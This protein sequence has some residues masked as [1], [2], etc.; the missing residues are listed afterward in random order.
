MAR[1]SPAGEP[2]ACRGRFVSTACC[3]G[4]R[5]PLMV[6]RSHAGRV[7]LGLLLLILLALAAAGCGEDD[8]PNTISKDFG[9]DGERLAKEVAEGAEKE[10]GDEVEVRCP[11]RVRLSDG[12]HVDCTAKVGGKERKIRVTRRGNVHEWRLYDFLDPQRV[13]R[14]IEAAFRERGTTV[15]AHCERVPIEEGRVSSCTASTAQREYRITVRQID[16]LGTI[17]WDVQQ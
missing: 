5:V 17:R 7:A 9:R 4:S 10:T 15:S 3:T 6:S 8:D 14:E 1:A 11:A 12:E 16:D 13:E 2:V